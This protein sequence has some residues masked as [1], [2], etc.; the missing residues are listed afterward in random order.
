MEGTWR[1]WRLQKWSYYN[2]FVWSEV[3]FR[4]IINIQPI[5][6]CFNSWNPTPSWLSIPSWD[7]ATTWHMTRDIHTA[8]Q[9]SLAEETHRWLVKHEILEC[10]IRN[11]M[12]DHLRDAPCC[13]IYSTIL[14]DLDMTGRHLKLKMP[15]TYFSRALHGKKC[16]GWSWVQKKLISIILWIRKTKQKRLTCKNISMTRR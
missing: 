2:L 3:C 15:N 6:F 1:R 8:H 4:E 7:K 5:V 12:P 10:K 13:T 14:F 11:A 9:Y 16:C